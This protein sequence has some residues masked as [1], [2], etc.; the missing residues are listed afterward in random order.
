MQ[1]LANQ[2]SIN[3]VSSYL[4]PCSMYNVP[5]SFLIDTGAGVSLL[6]GSVWDKIR[7]KDH[8]LRTVTVH[9]LV[10]VDGIPIRVRGSAW[11]QFS[12]G[13]MEFD[14]EFIIADHITAEAILGLDFLR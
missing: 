14:H 3:N 5:V 13:G 12:I 7:P 9:R 2:F 8:K 10:G 4:L 1:P 6:Q 11:I